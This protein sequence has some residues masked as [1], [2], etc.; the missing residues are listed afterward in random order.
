MRRLLPLLAFC[1]LASAADK[2]VPTADAAAKMKLPPGFKVSLFAGEPDVVQ[3]IAFTFDDRGRMWVVECLM[4]PKWSQDGKGGKDRVIILEDTDGDG[5]HDKRTVVLDDGVNLSGIELG[6]G[7][8]YLCS[9]PNLIFLPIKDDKPAGKPEVLLDGWNIKD[10]KHNVF[11]SLIWGPDGWLYGCNGIQT[12]SKV[13]K[14]GT[15]DKDRVPFDCGVWR[16]HPTRKVFEVVATGTTNPWGLDFDEHGEMFITNCVIDHLFHVVPGGRYTR[17][18]GQDYNPHTY[19]YMGSAVDYKHWGGGHWTE[20]RANQKTGEVKKEHDDAGGGHAHSGAAIYLGDNFPK[21]YRNTLFTANIHGNRLNNDGLERTKTGMKGVRRPDFLF[22]NDPWFRGICVKQGPAGE[23]FVSDWCDTGECHNYDVADTTNGRIY[24]VTYGDLKPFKGDV[25]KMTDEELVKAVTSQNEWLSR[26]ARRVLQERSVSTG[27]PKGLEVALNDLFR[28]DLSARDRLRLAWCKNAV[29]WLY[30]QDCQQMTKH[31]D[32]AVR[33]WGIRLGFDAK[34]PG[35]F[36]R[37]VVANLGADNSPIVR[38]VVAGQMKQLKGDYELAA[39]SGLLKHDADDADTKLMVWYAVETAGFD[40]SQLM[41]AK[42]KQPLLYDFL[43]RKLVAIADKSLS[44]A[45]AILKEL[46]SM[47][48]DEC[49]IAA[50]RGLSIGLAGVKTA[51]SQLWQSTYAH[52]LDTKSPELRKQLDELG[53]MLGDGTVVAFLKERIADG[54]KPA[55]ERERAVSLLAGRKTAGFDADLRKLLADPAVRA[56]A[57]RGLANYADDKTPAVLLEMYPKLTADEKADAVLTLSSRAA[58]ASALLDAV[59]KSTVPKGDITAFTARQIAGLKD[60]AVADKL[61]KVWGEVK[62]GTANAKAKI[63]EYK[64]KLTADDIAKGDAT[65]GKVLFAKTCGTCHKLFGEGQAVGPELTGSQRANL[66]YLLENVIDPNAVVPFD[67]K[68]TQFYLKDGRQ[69][70]GLVKGETP[71]TV[72]VRTVNE[73]VVL[74]KADID[75]RKGTNN[76]VMPEG[77]FDALK[78]DELRDLLKYLMSKDGR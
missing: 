47:P 37:E 69:L 59:E 43:S 46:P 6:F 71:Q 68:M 62:A 3:P 70:S 40:M 12:K 26:K 48:S 32:D 64:N 41:T 63:A 76:S 66:D 16:F 44:A 1:S 39:L 25:S 51:P 73:E 29:G 61:T 35:K 55:D 58:Y 19:G 7:G 50:V 2:P 67:Y 60:K 5:R 75:E 38:R 14:P 23:L 8:V 54:K 22:A 17:M 27:L 56:A 13:G 33:V 45:D 53:L 77:L 20:S 15:P 31:G 28:N 57:I 74:S 30:P 11:N 21:E 72:T 18:Y 4:Y 10:A 52:Y 49:R 34:E 42:A 65:R 36:I 9:S 24:R 78:P